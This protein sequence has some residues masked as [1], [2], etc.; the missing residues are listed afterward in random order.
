[1]VTIGHSLPIPLL[2]PHPPHRH[3]IWALFYQPR[4]EHQEY[5]KPWKLVEFI[6]TMGTCVINTTLSLLTGF[7]DSMILLHLKTLPITSLRVH[8][9]LPIQI[10]FICLDTKEIGNTWTLFGRVFRKISWNVSSTENHR[11]KVTEQSRLESICRFTEW[12][13]KAMNFYTL[14]FPK[15]ND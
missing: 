1:M 14:N 9:F 8:F 15:N 12:I 7:H 4:V 13:P 10:F 3:N 11:K 5:T 2:P 6:V